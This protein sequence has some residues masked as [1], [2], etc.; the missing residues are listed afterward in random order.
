MCAHG[1]R[2]SRAVGYACRTGGDLQI[3][4]FAPSEAEIEVFRAAAQREAL[5]YPRT[6]GVVPAGYV[7]QSE[8]G[9]VGTGREAWDKAV[10]A[11]MAWKMFDL[12][13]VRMPA[14]PAPE[15]VLTVAFATRQLGVWALHACRVVELPCERSE[16]TWRQGFVYGTL[17]SHA[18]SGEEA[19][20][21]RWDRATDRVW[22]GI[23]KFSRPRH[24]LVRAAGPVTRWLQATFSR[25]AVARIVS[26][27][28]F[29]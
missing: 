17:A 2:L 6:P 21:V 18:V 8:E 25:Q 5:S 15:V 10:A 28:R 9:C 1:S 22:F 20:L 4:G 7:A 29:H 27:I 24:P 16:Q 12:P 11:V 3:R 13:W 19:F 26:E 23:H 14:Y